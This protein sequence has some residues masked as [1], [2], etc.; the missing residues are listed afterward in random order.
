MFF[1]GMFVSIA[2]LNRGNYIF[3]I[4]FVFALFILNNMLKFFGKQKYKLKNTFFALFFIGVFII[5]IPQIKI[6]YD[7]GPI[8]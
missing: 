4:Y 5:S 2:A 1:S 6:N 8:T 3:G 7:K